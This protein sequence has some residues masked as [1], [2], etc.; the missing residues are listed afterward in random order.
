MNRRQRRAFEAGVKAG[1]T[2]RFPPAY[3]RLVERLIELI[4]QWIAAEPT[5]PDLR[6]HD[7]GE[8][9]T[10]ITG[11]L[12]GECLK[13]LADSSD[14]VRLCQWLDEKTDHQ[15]TLLQTSTALGFVGQIPNRS[16]IN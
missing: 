8:G 6:W 11:P 14:A 5:L 9:G 16:R 12:S 1:E 15:A 4:P 7:I 13:Y 2:G 3:I 10:L